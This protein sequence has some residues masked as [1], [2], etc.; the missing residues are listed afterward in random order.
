MTVQAV[1]N[2]VVLAE[3]DQTV[4]VEGNHYFP[5]DTLR[6]EFLAKSSS[7]SVCFWKGLAS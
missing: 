4:V 7:H 1:W 6:R 5:P 2:E 3:S